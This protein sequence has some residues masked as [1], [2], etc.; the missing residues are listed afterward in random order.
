MPLS[1]PYTLELRGYT[2]G[3][4]GDAWKVRRDQ[5]IGGFGH[6]APKDSDLPYEGRDGSFGGDDNEDV[7]VFTFPLRTVGSGLTDLARSEAAMANLLA[8]ET[9]W[10]AVTNAADVRLDIWLP[11]RRCY[12]NGRPRGLDPDLSGLTFGHITALATF[13]TTVDHVIHPVP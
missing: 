10:V 13:V 4:A 12:L 11:G 9:A 6:P 3:H 7:K 1:A 8:L 2:I 5:S